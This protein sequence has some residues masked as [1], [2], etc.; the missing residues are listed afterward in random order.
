MKL[1]QIL[2]AIILW[3][4]V[5]VRFV[6]LRA[7]WKPG[8]LLA[9]AFVA[10]GST[11]N[12]DPIYLEVDGW[13]GSRNVLNL[14]VH[15]AIGVGMTELSRLMLAATSANRSI[16]R[17]LVATGGVLVGGQIVLLM[18]ADTSGSATNLTE[19]YGSLPAII[20]YQALFFVW[21]GVITAFTGAASLRRDRQPESRLFRV[22][23]DIIA[24]SCIVGVVAVGAKLLLIGLAAYGTAHSVAEIMHSIYRLL[25]ATTLVGFAVGFALPAYQRVGDYL[26]EKRWLDQALHQLRPMVERLVETDAG[27]RA[28]VASGLALEVGDPRE[29]LYRWLIFLGDVRAD[30]PDQLSKRE[31]ALLKEIEEKI[32]PSGSLVT[33]ITSG[34]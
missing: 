30:S 28:G 11:L 25:I 16:W 29:R 18:L 7:G 10:T 13:L 27:V 14:V 34:S 2:P 19:S 8:I 26:K 9:M 21:I 31:N 24:G 22:G 12:V 23:F 33:K 5:L 4:V 15:I 20:W 17:S 1:V 32:A 3:S 6:G